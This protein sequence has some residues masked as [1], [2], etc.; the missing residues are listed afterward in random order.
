[1]SPASAEAV[2]GAVIATA[3]AAQATINRLLIFPPESV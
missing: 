1:L 2:P 3:S